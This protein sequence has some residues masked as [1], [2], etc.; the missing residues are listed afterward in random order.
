[1][2][3]TNYFTV[4]TPLCS[5]LTFSMFVTNYF[6]VPTPLCSVLTFSM[7]VTNY[8]T[9]PTPL[10]S[11]LTF[12]M[13]VTNYFT[14]PTP[15]CS[16]LTFSMFVTNYFT[17]PTPLCSVLTFSMFVTNYFTVPT[18]LC[19]VLTFSMFHS[20]SDNFTVP[21]RPSIIGGLY[22]QHV[23]FQGSEIILQFNVI[24]VAT[25]NCP[26][27]ITPISTS[28]Q[29]LQ[30]TIIETERNLNCI[31]IIVFFVATRK[32]PSVYFIPSIFH[33]LKIHVTPCGQ[34]FKPKKV[35]RTSPS[36]KYMNGAPRTLWSNHL[37][38]PVFEAI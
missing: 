31:I 13:F 7:F 38:V 37:N 22:F 24:C 9:V 27:H 5:V 11:V 23:L 34:N 3:V 12:S 8:F 21:T 1:M 36:L 16:V 33:R 19:S 14:V 30:H 18:P 4:P 32:N 25:L 20:K 17:V 2:F 10:C 15:L 6:T 28:V 29:N 26:V 35:T